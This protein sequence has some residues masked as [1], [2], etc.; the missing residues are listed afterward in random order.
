MMDDVLDLP[1]LHEPG[2]GREPLWPTLWWTLFWLAVGGVVAWLL[3]LDDLV[4]A[5]I[6]TGHLLDWITGGLCL[7]WL[8]VILK[9]PWD[10]LFQAREVQFE[11]Q[12]SRERAI[13][14]PP[15]R[16]AYVAGLG[17]RLAWL[18]VGAHLFSAVL[19]AG[20]T[21]LTGG[22]VGYYF[23]GFYL[24]A[25]AFRPLV[26]AY[27]YLWRRL[28]AIGREVRY[29]RQDVVE[30]RERLLPQALRMEGLTRQWEQHTQEWQAERRELR[31]SVQSLSRHFETV[32]SSL[33]DNQEVIHG[34]QALARLVAQSSQT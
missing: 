18:A 10:L 3:D 16:E 26:A 12:R 8:V 33:T 28:R 25:T 14:I 21:S 29:P 6:A 30:L 7:V 13:P 9:A 4:R 5:S 34:I 32:A 1:V 15:Q 2:R 20:I 27:V 23:A 17:R 11:L 19:V 22:R 24:V 31:Q